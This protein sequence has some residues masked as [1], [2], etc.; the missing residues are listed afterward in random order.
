MPKKTVKKNWANKPEG[1]SFNKHIH[2][3]SSDTPGMSAAIQLLCEDVILSMQKAAKKS[4]HLAR[5]DERIAQGAD[6]S[7]ESYARIKADLD[8]AK[9]ESS[10]L[11]AQLAANMTGLQIDYRSHRFH[12]NRDG[13]V[14]VIAPHDAMTLKGGK[15]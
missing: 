1:Y 3:P 6:I 5:V 12:R 15:E 10:R 2:K 4:A 14:N 13:I 7:P 11:K 9:A 8:D